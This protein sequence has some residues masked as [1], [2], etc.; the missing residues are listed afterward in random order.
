LKSIPGFEKSIEKDG[1]DSRSVQ[2]RAVGWK[3]K[4]M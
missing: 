2:T 3:K 1:V 4:N